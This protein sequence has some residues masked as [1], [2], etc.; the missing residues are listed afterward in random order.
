MV[1]HS[2]RCSAMSEKLKRIFF[3]IFVTSNVI[4][5]LPTEYRSDG[6]L[7]MERYGNTTYTEICNGYRDLVKMILNH[8]S[9]F[10]KLVTIFAM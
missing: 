5:V 4:I 3:A 6:L 7:H 1:T 10:D 9:M 2:Q 8:F